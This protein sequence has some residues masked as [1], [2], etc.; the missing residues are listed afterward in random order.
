M[1]LPHG[2]VAWGSWGLSQAGKAPNR[3]PAHSWKMQD[4]AF[5]CSFWAAIQ[6]FIVLSPM[7]P[8]ENLPFP[9][10]NTSSP[11]DPTL[12]SPPQLEP[13]SAQQMSRKFWIHLCHRRPQ[14][15]FYSPQSYFTILKSLLKYL[16]K[17]SRLYK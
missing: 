7:P 2:L 3:G 8:R 13:T 12:S 9:R 5:P 14:S 1:S 15:G 10:G 11:S 16:N 17:I 4:S 6:F